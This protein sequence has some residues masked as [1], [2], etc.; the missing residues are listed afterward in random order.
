MILT[1]H[2]GRQLSN[3]LLPSLTIALRDHN[4]GAADIPEQI[5]TRAAS[6]RLL[7]VVLE[8]LTQALDQFRNLN[9]HQGVVDTW[10]AYQHHFHSLDVRFGGLT[11]CYG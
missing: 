10:G 7:V 8:R 11:Y 3:L 5:P 4:L 1:L 2:I 6:Q 9:T